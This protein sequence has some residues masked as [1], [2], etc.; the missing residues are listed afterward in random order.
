MKRIVALFLTVLI[1]LFTGCS[2]QQQN[3]KTTTIV[4]TETTTMDLTN[5][6]LDF[7]GLNDPE[8]L[9]Y[10]D[11]CIY[12]DL[13][14]SLDNNSYSVYDID[15]VFI[16]KEALEE[17]IYNSQE[18]IYFG[19]KLSE[20]EGLFKDDKYVF[21]LGEDG[22][23]TVKAHEDYEESFEK[24]IIK[25]VAMGTGVIFVCVILS[26]AT[27]GVGTGAVSVIFAASANTATQFA[28]SSALFGGVTSG[29]IT[30][31]QTGSFDQA[32]KAAALSG[33]EG[34]K[35][36]AITGAVVGGGQEALALYKAKKAADAA[37]SISNAIPS[38]LD[39]E[40]AAL[41][42]YGG[43]QQVS[44][45]NGQEVP[46]GTLGSTRPD[47]VRTVNGH[48]E[49]IEVKRFDLSNQS[50]V[51]SL[52]RS[53]TK[54]VSDRVAHMPAG[55]TQ[56]VVLN[57]AG[58]GYTKAFV[59]AKIAEIQSYLSSVYAKMPIDIMGL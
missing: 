42:K 58:R 41:A 47:I 3:A 2:A 52:C 43:K 44:Y 19:Y 40:I 4:E 38:P 10:V 56:R 31:I 51:D 26:V 55:T 39:A 54:E 28:L 33:S 8:L 25:N 22:V 15:T 57:V 9:T 13:N 50:S 34:F 32:L 37:S 59:N 23:T 49:A 45:I 36:G 14:N 29:I 35:W 12:T 48:L 24:T 18:N 21:T 53:L 27:A 1:F 30:G 7:K 16:S 6:N 11:D 20:L 46:C 5:H 17:T